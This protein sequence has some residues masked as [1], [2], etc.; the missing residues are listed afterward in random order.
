MWF[1]AAEG[2][3]VVTF[4]PPSAEDMVILGWTWAA[5]LVI[6][7]IALLARSGWN[8]QAPGGWAGMFEHIY[9]WVHGLANGMMGSVGKNYVPFTMTIFLLL[10][11]SNWFGLLPGF[12]AV[13][14]REGGSGVSLVW[15]TVPKPVEKKAEAATEQPAANGEREAA[16]KEEEPV[17]LLEAPTSNL[18][19]TLALALVSFLSFTL[20]G[21][22]EHYMAV[23]TGGH[24]HHDDHGHD[25]V[26]NTGGDAHLVES[27]GSDP[28]SSVLFGF[29]SWLGHF[30]QP[31]PMLWKSMDGALK[32]LLVPPMC[33]LFICLNIVE[34]LARVISLTLRLFGNIAG[35]H[36]VKVG[37]FIV[38]G[39]FGGM[40]MS[41]LQ[42]SIFIAGTN[43]VL[44]AV[45]WGISVFVTLI[46]ALAGFVQAMVFM[47][48]TMSYISH[49]V[50]LE[51]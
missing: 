14:G 3:G 1:L 13:E 35:E 47:L 22:H 34:E 32:Y 2:G 21:L 10:I 41:G 20:F 11:V 4:T 45:I 36:Q 40:A 43:G 49:A 23:R 30:V 18:N 44:S 24:G 15:S 37:L 50:A 8:Q 46:G 7:A 38:M 26:M 16:A 42:E 31:T 19:T 17:S 51:H 33:L 25:E 27:R 9:H 48:L 39:V 5:M 29:I 6:L 12:G 28:V